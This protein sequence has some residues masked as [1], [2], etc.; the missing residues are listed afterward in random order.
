VSL[1]NQW[2]WA[3][4]FCLGFGGKKL[5]RFSPTKFWHHTQT[6]LSLLALSFSTGVLELSLMDTYV[7]LLYL[8]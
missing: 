1:E 6:S 3:K 7:H 2:R 5:V 4:I 8:G